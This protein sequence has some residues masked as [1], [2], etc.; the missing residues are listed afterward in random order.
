M[1]TGKTR[2]I[3]RLIESPVGEG[4]PRGRSQNGRIL[5]ITR[6]EEMSSSCDASFTNASNVSERGT[7]SFGMLTSRRIA[8]KK[9]GSYLPIL[10]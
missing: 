2:Q 4:C 6:T 7:L 10:D 5:A 8:G 1:C 3:P 9:F